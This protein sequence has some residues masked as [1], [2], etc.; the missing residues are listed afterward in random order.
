MYA[1]QMSC[2]A[3][4]Y[5]AIEKASIFVCHPPVILHNA[6]LALGSALRR[7][8]RQTFRKRASEEFGAN[9]YI[10]VKRQ[11]HE[12]VPMPLEANV[13][14]CLCHRPLDDSNDYGK[15]FLLDSCSLYSSL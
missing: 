8:S 13:F 6:S 9:I 7:G 5:Q 14:V 12:Y 2:P 11:S 3:N 10:Y 4:N 15:T 1:G